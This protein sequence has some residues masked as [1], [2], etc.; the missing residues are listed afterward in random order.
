MRV[1]N[2]NKKV[3]KENLKN[4][5]PQDDFNKPRVFKIPSEEAIQQARRVQPDANDDDLLLR[6]IVEVGNIDMLQ[7]RVL[8]HRDIARHWDPQNPIISLRRAINTG[9]Q[10]ILVDLLSVYNQKLS[11]WTLNTALV[12][13]PELRYLLQS[14]KLFFI[15]TAA[16]TLKLILKNFG[17]VISINVNQPPPSGGGVDISREER[18]EKCHD[19]YAHLNSI[20]DCISNAKF[21][22][23]TPEISRIFEEVKRAFS[24][25]D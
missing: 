25:L 6:R 20:R 8:T 22:S 15:Q 23:Y 19:S 3:S 13:L 12:V 2:F 11:L 18:Y 21:D 14:Q 16:N 7:N 24:V 4:P 10:A 17:P 5:K 1:H 9:D